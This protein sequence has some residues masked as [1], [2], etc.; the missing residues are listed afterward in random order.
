[1]ALSRWSHS[2][3]YI[4]EPCGREQGLQ[5]SLFGYF[6]LG[7]ILIRYDR[8]DAKAKSEGASFTE[9]LELRAYMKSWAL[10][11]AGKMDRRRYHRILKALRFY[12]HVRYYCREP[13]QW[14]FDGIMDALDRF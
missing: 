12:G 8:I 13:N 3:W 7:D 14:N 1:M 9:R 11:Q 2:E 6:T 10:W 5:V 4:Y